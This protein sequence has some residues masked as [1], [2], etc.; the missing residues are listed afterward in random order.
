[1]DKFNSIKR[2]SIFGVIGNIINGC[3]ENSS[4]LNSGIT[5]TISNNI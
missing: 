4:T 2:A 3:Q 1:M 5:K